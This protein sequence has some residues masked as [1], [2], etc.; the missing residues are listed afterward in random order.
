MFRGS[1]VALVT[2]LKNDTIDVERL[3]ALVEW[4]IEAGTHG[5]IAAGTTGE[6]GTLSH[7]EKLIV[8]KHVIE[9]ANER[10]AVIAGTAANSTKD[11]I[12][13]TNEAMALGADAALIMAPAYIKPTQEGLFHHYQHIAQAVPLPLIL[14]NVPGRTACDLLPET[15]IKLAAIPNII[16]IK[17]ATGDKA[18]LL[19][20]L[21]GCHE[22]LDVFSGDDVTAADWLLSGAKGV[23][24][25]TANVVPKLMAKLCD[26][27]H[28]GDTKACLAIN[29]LLHALHNLL[30][31]ESN[32]IPVKWA[33]A[34]MGLIGEDIRLPLTP[35]SIIH[36]P[37]LEQA[38]N[39]LSLVNT[40][41]VYH[42]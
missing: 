42:A 12:T 39:A 26:A 2:P 10:I 5:I 35:L 36:Q 37:A 21:E 11:C 15:V 14:Y 1:M 24:S 22:G 17:E 40:K 27:A 33:M 3:R 8:I 23:I 19:T 25:V 32:P 31:V 30:F 20:L 38:L 13:L 34:K 4:H 7:E 6:S 41:K 16:G 9:Q 28:D 18:R 29:D